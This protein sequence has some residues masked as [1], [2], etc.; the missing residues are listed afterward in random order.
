MRRAAAVGA[1]ALLAL[2]AC[3]AAAAAV[4]SS[5]SAATC[6]APSYDGTAFSIECQIP[7]ATTTVAGPTVTRTVT[8]TVTASPSPSKTKTT[9]ASPTPTPT[10][11]L[12]APSG[13]T[14]PADAGFQ[15]DRSKLA[16]VPDSMVPAGCV[17]DATLKYL[18]CKSAAVLDHVY[19]KGGVD[20]YGDL[21]IT[22]SVISANPTNWPLVNFRSTGTCTVLRSTLVFN[23][24]GKYPSNVGSWGV[25]GI[26]D[27]NGCRG[28]YEDNDISGTPDGIDTGTDGT[29]IRGNYI[30]NLAVVGTPPNDTHNDGIQLFGCTGCDIEGNY[31]DI[32][33][34]GVHQNSCFFESD[35]DPG[36]GI[37]FSGNYLS[38]GGYAFRNMIGTNMTVTNNI[39]H[40]LPNQWDQT[41]VGPG[42]SFKAWTGNVTTTGATVP[43]PKP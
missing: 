12:S 2:A 17:W 41:L 22:D 24:G 16:I 10:P 26:N 33:W 8:R 1:V 21:T 7:Q 31:F 28:D 29:V 35:G 18:E 14:P 36:D 40:P 15:G 27:M 42:A 39:F 43:K 32:G 4:D 23:N 9:S 37:T 11:S 19:V 38:G 3:S 5:P 13:P 6:D 30:H 25:G 34:D 20:A